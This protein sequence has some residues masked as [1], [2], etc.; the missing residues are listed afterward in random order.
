MALPVGGE[1]AYTAV[2]A[3][4]MASY[5]LRSDGTVDRARSKGKVS[6]RMVAPEGTTYTQV[7]F[8]KHLDF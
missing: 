2:S 1:L 6:N 8:C 4:D 5:F 7:G 3:G